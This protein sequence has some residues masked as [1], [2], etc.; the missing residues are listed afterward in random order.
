MVLL[1]TTVTEGAGDAFV[2]E[3]EAVTASAAGVRRATGLA[4][5]AGRL[6]TRSAADQKAS[7]ALSSGCDSGCWPKATLT[8]AKQ[9][10]AVPAD[11]KNAHAR[12][13]LF[14]TRVADGPWLL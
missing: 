6:P 10:A 8:Q 9:A 14:L 3:E 1:S 11:K 5:A 12:D 13:I 4:C 2:C 7:L